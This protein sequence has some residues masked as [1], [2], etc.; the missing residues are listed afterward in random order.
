MEEAIDGLQR[1]PGTRPDFADGHAKSGLVLAA[2]GRREEARVALER[3]LALKPELADAHHAL[4]NLLFDEGRFDDAVVSLKKAVAQRPDALEPLTDLGTAQSAAGNLPGA[5]DTYM[6]CQKLD[7]DAPEPR[8]NLGIVYHRQQ[9]FD[10]AVECLRGVVNDH[11]EFAPA[12]N[13]L[14]T[15]LESNGAILEAVDC[16]REAVRLKPD[17]FEAYNNLGAALRNAGK[18]NEAVVCFEEALRLNAD[19]PEALSG[20]GVALHESAQSDEGRA[21]LE[22]AVAVKP[23]FAEAHGNLA[24]LLSDQGDT[25]AAL[26]R[27]D[28]A[29]RLDPALPSIHHNRAMTLLLSG[30]FERG[31]PEY[32]WRWRLP[33]A[34]PRTW[35][36]P[37]WDGSPLEGKRILLHREQ[38]LGDTLQ[39][40][41]YAPMVQQQGGKVLILAP[42]TWLP[43]LK[44]CAG[45][46][47]DQVEF[48]DEAEPLPRF[49]VFASLMTLPGLFKTDLS[50]IPADV[51][52][53]SVPDTLIEK[54]RKTLGDDDGGG[55]RVGIAWQGNPNFAG[56]RLRSFPLELFAPLAAIDGVSLVS[57]QKGPGTE[58]LADAGFAVKDVGSQFSDEVMMDAGAVIKNLD[59][60]VSC[61]SAMVHLAG[62]LAAPTWVAVPAAPDWRWL[63]ERDD[64]PWYPT[65]RLFRQAAAGEWAHVF[66]RIAGEL[67]RQAAANKPRRTTG[68]GQ[69]DD[70]FID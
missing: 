48:C 40:I 10:E 33:N 45:L 63:L 61:D 2:L 41:R 31:W 28:E 58:Q 70:T 56:D 26:A 64:S 22:R 44:S 3:A 21:A 67:S 53:L 57:L 23:D 55:L 12:H 1:V 69:P 66:E 51:P 11:P 46:N 8:V 50:S 68:G 54:W 25:T 14:G 18:L 42:K 6:H 9:R 7:P 5:V 37:Q 59:L 4:G 32:E 38:G 16:F 60:V 36:Q 49:D 35:K 24:Q 43:I 65:V 27:Y 19:Q 17:F 15:V 30:D 34:L 62:A 52:Y 39:F 20:L 47:P 29:L 13:A